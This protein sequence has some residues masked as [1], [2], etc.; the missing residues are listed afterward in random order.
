MASTQKIPRLR[1]VKKKKRN[2]RRLLFLLFLFFM[3]LLL[4]L[5]VRSSLGNISVITKG[6]YWVSDDEIINNLGIKSGSLLLF[7]DIKEL[8]QRT[9]SSFPLIQTVTIQKKYPATL[10]VA[11]KEK[12]VVAYLEKDGKSYPVFENGTFLSSRSLIEPMGDKPR[13]NTWTDINILPTFIK[14]LN[15]LEPGVRSLISEIVYKKDGTRPDSLI[16]YM[17]EGYEVRTTVAEF[18]KNMSWYPSFVKSIKQEG[19]NRGIIYLSEVKYFEP[20]QTQ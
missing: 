8:E 7:I 11:S 17:K 12:N 6:N 19:N 15:Q 5:F 1:V 20:Y 18:A 13:L 2:N 4:I 3:S 14:E 10:E 16:L 9:L